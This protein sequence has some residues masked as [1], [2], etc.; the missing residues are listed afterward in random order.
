MPPSTALS[1]TIIT[2]DEADRIARCVRAARAVADEVLVVDSGSTD[3][4]TAIAE[5]E[6]ARVLHRDWTGYGPQKRFAEL[7]ASCDWILSLDADEVLSPEL[8]AE[9]KALMAAG[10]PLAAYR[11]RI[12]GM[13]PGRDR[14]HLGSRSYNVVRLYDRRRATYSES[15]IHDRVETGSLE[16][17]QLRGLVHHYSFRSIAHLKEKLDAYATYQLDHVRKPLLVLLLRAPFEY[18]LTFLKY[19]IF[20]GNITAGWTGVVISHLPAAARA[21]RIWALIGRKFAGASGAP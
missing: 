16:V 3:E 13:I 18:P 21:R 1:C 11:L 12:V 9:I 20:R 5:R 4:T 19:L 2:R 7:E 6:G 10:P 17:G 14:P 15:P 8:Q